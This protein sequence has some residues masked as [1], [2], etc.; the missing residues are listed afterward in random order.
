ML[1]QNESLKNKIH[2]ITMTASI[3]VLW[4]YIYCI[5]QSLVNAT[6]NTTLNNTEYNFVINTINQYYNSNIP[7]T[8]E[9]EY[10][11]GISFIDTLSKAFNLNK[12]IFDLDINSK[13][14][15]STINNEY[16]FYVS[17]YINN[18]NNNYTETEIIILFEPYIDI[19]HYHFNEYIYYN[20][21]HQYLSMELIS[22]NMTLHNLT[23][24]ERNDFIPKECHNIAATQLPDEHRDNW[25]DVTNALFRDI[26]DFLR[27][28]FIGIL[29]FSSIVV[30]AGYIHSWIVWNY[31]IYIGNGIFFCFAMFDWYSD[32]LFTFTIPVKYIYLWLISFCLLLLP[33]IGNVGWLISSQKIWEQ[34][35]AIGARVKAWLIRWRPFLYSL[36]IITGSS[37]GGINM[38]NSNMFGYPLFR[39]GLRGIHLEKFD[40]K[41]LFITVLGENAPQLVL[42]AYYWFVLDYNL[43]EFNENKL[44]L[45]LAM[46]SGIISILYA[47]G[48]IYSSKITLS[49]FNDNE[50]ELFEFNIISAKDFPTK[51]YR[52]NQSYKYKMYPLRKA[53]ASMFS[54]ELQYVE[55][56]PP[57]KIEY[58]YQ[59]RFTLQVTQLGGN[60]KA[61]KVL[62]DLIQHQLLNSKIQDVWHLDNLPDITELK[63]KKNRKRDYQEN[64]VLVQVESKRRPIKKSIENEISMSN[65]Y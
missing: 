44:T 32:I 62:K 25:E 11:I 61:F 31:D 9:L 21:L 10:Y 2:H 13:I 35:A 7:S 18:S 47:F 4:L 20:F 42:Q 54:L 8:Q 55:L 28:I 46:I 48:V 14:N 17:P 53:F 52:K 56:H 30:I 26:Y 58:G 6:S 19:K 36:T 23:W 5:H 12:N 33:L 34:D 40:S 27:W 51:D 60:T 39:M 1:E 63:W 15:I 50:C 38:C 65:T 24:I 29:G 57:I 37:F 45:G 3:L 49:K 59:L 41:R 43:D 64:M 16:S 22:R